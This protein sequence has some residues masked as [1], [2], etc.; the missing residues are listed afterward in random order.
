[1]VNLVTPEP[2]ESG[3]S[4]ELRARHRDVLTKLMPVNLRVLADWETIQKDTEGI[5]VK[6]DAGKQVEPFYVNP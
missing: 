4:E 6:T 5:L 2:E 3:W 1:M